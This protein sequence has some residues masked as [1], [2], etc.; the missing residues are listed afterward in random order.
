MALLLLAHSTALCRSGK[1]IKEA[2]AG[3]EDKITTENSKIKRS[4][5]GEIQINENIWKPKRKW[6]IFPEAENDIKQKEF[7]E[8]LSIWVPG[9]LS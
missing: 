3:L 1:V 6:K 9:W 2:S 5:K 4:G 8:S 7:L